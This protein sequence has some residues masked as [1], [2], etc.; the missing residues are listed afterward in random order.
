M[1]QI[2]SDHKYCVQCGAQIH[3]MAE[4][5]PTCGVRQPSCQKKSDDSRWLTT[6][7]LCW[8]VGYFGVHRFYTGY[9]AI[10][11]IQLL[12]GGGCGIWWLIDFI[13]IIVGSY[14]D[15]DGNPI[16]SA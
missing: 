16:K 6:L 7:L 1:E 2:N 3:P 15:S 14:K 13:K 12:T 9:T 4:I 11:V 10:G 5:C 8:F